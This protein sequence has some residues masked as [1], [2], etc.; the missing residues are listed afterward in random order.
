MSAIP[1]IRYTI[2]DYLEIERSTGNRYEFH[3]GELFEVEGASLHHNRILMNT[4]KAVIPHLS[5]KGC[6]V[7]TSQLKVYAK[8]Q[9]SITYPD[10]V[11]VCG[12]VETTKEFEDIVTNPSVIIEIVSPSTGDY[13]HGKKFQ[14][15]RELASLKE[16]ILIS[17]MEIRVEKF[18]RQG[19]TRWTLEEYI[20]P[21]QTFTIDRI[22][23]SLPVSDVYAN[24][25]LP[26]AFSI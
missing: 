3:D 4:V 26:P 7:F 1:V 11:I 9:N 17:S 18:T 5:E 22:G 20:H 12:A 13:D 16:Y 23:L 8:S 15:Y 14:L 10:L 6:E 24:T 21:H 2:T 19:S 25:D